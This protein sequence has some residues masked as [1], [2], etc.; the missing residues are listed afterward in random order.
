MSRELRIDGGVAVITGAASGIG[1]GLA[2]HAAGLGMR[3][4]LADINAAQLELVACDLNTDVLAIAVDVRDPQAVDGLAAAAFDRFGQVDLL[5]NN[6]GIVSTGLSWEIPLVR[7]QQEFDVNVRGVLH[8]IHAFVP[9]LLK[10]GRPA[11]IINTSSVGGFLPSAMMSPYTATKAAVV[12]MTE[13]LHAELRLLE[14]PVGVSLLGPGPVQSAIF[15]DPFTT[16]TEG[17]DARVGEFTQMLRTMLAEYGLSPER[18]AEQ[19]FAA[20][21][22]QAFWI[23]PQP[24]ALDEALHRRMQNILARENPPMSWS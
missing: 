24:E 6:A 21:R 10:A 11:H 23:L 3:L 20:I 14:A 2:R 7:W 4:V 18:F 8:G 5:F 12:A 1:M 17:G 16:G 13:S 15:N 22:Q 9:R 19:V